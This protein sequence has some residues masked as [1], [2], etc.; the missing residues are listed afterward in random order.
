VKRPLFGLLV[1][2]MLL[3]PASAHAV[4]YLG[5]G[6]ARQ[7]IGWYL[8]THF[9]YGAEPGSLVAYC[10]R[11]ARNWVRCGISWVDLDG[12]IWGGRASVRETETYYRVR[13]YDEYCD[14]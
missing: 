10:S 12:D 6:E 3:A 8:R 4:P 14:C 1:A 11:L 9:E 7:Q 5:G 2:V 13:L